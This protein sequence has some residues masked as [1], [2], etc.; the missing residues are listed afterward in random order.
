MLDK[1]KAWLAPDYRE[2]HRSGKDCPACGIH[3]DPSGYSWRTARSCLF[4]CD[5]DIPERAGKPR[6]ASLRSALL[7]ADE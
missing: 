5:Y 3:V 6:H 4:Y 2:L 7:N 1:L